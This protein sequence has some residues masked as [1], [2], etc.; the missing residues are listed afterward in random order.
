MERH[1]GIFHG[2]KWSCFITQDLSASRIRTHPEKTVLLTLFALFV[3]SREEIT[4]SFFLSLY[5]A[6]R[7]VTRTIL[8]ENIWM[9]DAII[10]EC[11]RTWE[12][13]KGILR[14]VVIHIIHSFSFYRFLPPDFPINKRREKTWVN[15]MMYYYCCNS[16]RKCLFTGIWC[17]VGLFHFM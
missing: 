7:N 1:E 16:Q 9:R 17:K 3:F 15:K 2:A 14:C 8:Y 5:C 10:K 6:L 4:S 13:Q 12:K 11:R